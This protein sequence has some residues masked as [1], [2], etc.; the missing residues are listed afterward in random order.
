MKRKN[1]MTVKRYSFL[2]RL[3]HLT[4]LVTLFVLL[5]TGFKIYAGWDFIPYHVA[6]PIHMFAAVVFVFVNWVIIPYNVFT[7]ECPRCPMCADKAH[8][9]AIHRILHIAHRYLFGPTD[10]KRMKQIF[11]NYLGKADYPAFTI[12][13]V[14]NEGYIDKLHPVTQFMLFFEG[15]AVMFV[16]FTGIVLYNL[17]WTL[18]GLPVSEW[19][20]TIS[21]MVAPSLNMSALGFIRTMHLFMAYFFIIELIVHVGIIEFDPKVLKYHKAIFLTG[22][23]EL[24]D[25]SYVELIDA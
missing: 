10:I 7:T 16:A 9:I 17:Q 1:T 11:L 23:E 5:I 14:K 15:G 20:Y 4:H 8:N 3:A 2:E 13:D 18:F 22:E 24:T 19:L 25:S 6:L 21:E 12:Y